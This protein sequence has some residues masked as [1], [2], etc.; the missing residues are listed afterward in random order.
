MILEEI[1]LFLFHKIQRTYAS[2][3]SFDQLIIRRALAYVFPLGIYTCAVLA[4]LRI[5]AFVDIRAISARAVQLVSLVALATEHAEYILATAEHAQV[6]EHLALVYI[7]ARLLVALVGVHE[8]HLA[9]A[10]KRSRII[11][12]VAILAKGVV[13]GAFV[14]VL[15]GV[16]VPSK[17]SVA[18]ALRT[19]VSQ[20]SST[21][22]MNKLSFWILNFYY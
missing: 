2:V 4:R 13:V 14:D 11:E 3:P 6:A 10:S 12:A 19:S 20:L 1:T 16:A 5:L 17:P 21:V 8:A 22:S 15:T 7:D 9:L 18:I